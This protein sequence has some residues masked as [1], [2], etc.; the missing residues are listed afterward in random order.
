MPGRCEAL[1]CGTGRG[2]GGGESLL[3]KFQFWSP[4]ELNHF[5]TCRKGV[6]VRGGE[7]SNWKRPMAAVFD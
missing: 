7:A 2:D 1:N 4:V 5:N 3:C 6:E